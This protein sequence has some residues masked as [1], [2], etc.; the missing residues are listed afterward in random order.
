MTFEIPEELRESKETWFKF[1]STQSL[2]ATLVFAS[3]GVVFKIIFSFFGAELLG[4]FVLVLFALTGF[5]LFTVRL[6]GTN[7][8]HGGRLLLSQKIWRWFLHRGKRGVYLPVYNEE[9]DYPELAGDEAENE[10]R[11]E[12]SILT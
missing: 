5:L 10:D 1:F 12:V 6:P 7:T 4:W 2:I 9:E 11:D 8:L 3:I